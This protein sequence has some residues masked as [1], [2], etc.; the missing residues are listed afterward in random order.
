MTTAATAFHV[1]GFG[2]CGLAGS[3]RGLEKIY[4]PEPEREALLGRMSAEF[5]DADFSP[6]GF[7]GLQQELLRFFRGGVPYFTSRLYYGRATIFQKKVWQAARS[8]KYGQVRT[9]GWLAARIGRPRAMRAVGA[10]LGR[11]PFPI[12]VPCH[13]ILRRDGGLGGFSAT[14]GL[15]LKEKLLQLEGSL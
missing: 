10:A 12:L 1:P 4:L 8:V 7:S 13:R 2:W 5:P 6:D 9:Y 15:A 3:G 14:G 11:N